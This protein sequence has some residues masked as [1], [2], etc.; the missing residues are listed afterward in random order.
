MATPQ[1]YAIFKARTPAI[2]IPT[3]CAILSKQVKLKL[4][5]QSNIKKPNLY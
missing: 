1:P 4:K 3:W 5:K 2:L